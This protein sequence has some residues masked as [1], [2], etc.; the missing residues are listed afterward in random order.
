MH[1][2]AL[3][4]QAAQILKKLY[5]DL[6]EL[7]VDVAWKSDWIF[8]EVLVSYRDGYIRPSLLRGVPSVL[9]I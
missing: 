8:I 5:L 1:N 9:E 4:T 6:V 3:G 2:A 7:F